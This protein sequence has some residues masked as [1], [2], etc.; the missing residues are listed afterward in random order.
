MRR[1]VHA[2]TVNEVF[3]DEGDRAYQAV[4]LET[5]AE[6]DAWSFPEEEFFRGRRTE[7][8]AI[9]DA[10]SYL[11]CMALHEPESTSCCLAEHAMAH[12]LKAQP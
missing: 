1:V 6:C 5:G 7:G 8:E 4:C 11:S 3:D 9:R 2:A 12:D 10:L